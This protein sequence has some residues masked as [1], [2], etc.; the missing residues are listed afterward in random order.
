ME[1]VLKENCM[2]NLSNMKA[3]EASKFP[4]VLNHLGSNFSTDQE[5]IDSSGFQDFLGLVLPGVVI[6]HENG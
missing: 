3:K 5:Y 6:C 2:I 1:G 4:W